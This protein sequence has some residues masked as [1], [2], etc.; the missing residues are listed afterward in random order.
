MTKNSS[1][2][3][4][5]KNMALGTTGVA[6][7]MTALSCKDPKGKTLAEAKEP[8]DYKLKGNINH[9]VCYWCY[10]SFTIEDFSKEVAAL[11]MPAID[12]LTPAEWKVAA[13]HGVKCA[14]GTETFA[15]IQNGFNV[16]D[17]HSRL[18]QQYEGLIKEAAK[19][20]VPNVIVFSG[21]QRELS[22]EKGWE[23]CVKGLKPLAEIA[24][25]EGVTLIMEL[26]NSKVDHKDYQN[27]H[28]LWGVEL[29]KRLGSDSF[30]L[31]YDI[32]HMQIMEGDVIRT[33]KEHH[34]YIAHYHT[35]GVPGRNEINTSQ[36]LYYPAIMQAIVDTGFKGYVAQE[37]I[38]TYD[39]KIAALKEG[40]Q[41]CDV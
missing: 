7:G 20:G 6:L 1:R 29:C 41:I 10:N 2:R 4:A 13:K 26:L 16:V 5:L 40:V 31:L 11:G 19:D 21:N 36:E 23:N 22:D 12:L 30:K 38:P 32:Y 15:D 3:N 37:F 27:D 28:T 34:P 39:D 9:S 24:E 35:G 17:N 8:E 18:Q 25:S 14:V 33:I